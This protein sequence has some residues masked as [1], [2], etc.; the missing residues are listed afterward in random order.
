[1]HTNFIQFLDEYKN[2]SKLDYSDL[3][4]I[5]N[6]TNL[7][8]IMFVGNSPILLNPIIQSLDL[9]R[10]NPHKKESADDYEVWQKKHEVQLVVKT[11]SPS[12][13][14]KE[15]IFIETNIENVG[16]LLKLLESIS[17]DETKEYNIDLHKLMKIKPE[18]EELH[19]MIGIQELKSSILDQLFYFLQDLHLS[20]NGGDFKH[21]VIYG[22][23]GTGKTEVAKII[24]RMF[25][26]IGIL[27]NNV[28]KKVVRSDLVA[29]YLGQ[30]AI[31]TKT[32]IQESLGGVLFID[33]AYSLAFNTETDNY[34]QECIDTLCEALSD[35]KDDLMVIVAGYENE[36]NQTFFKANKGLESRFIWRFKIDNYTAVELSNIFCKKVKDA[37]WQLEQSM[38]LGQE[39]WFEQKKSD[40]KSFGRDM[41]ILF[42]YTKI[43]H[44][45]RIYGK[46]LDQRKCISIVDM[47]AGFKMFLKNKAGKPDGPKFG[48]MYI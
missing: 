14:Q 18:L 36:M 4:K 30:T 6:T 11:E 46:S 22:P 44:A 41:E 28:F 10:E 16:D 37:E 17:I 19:Q 13:P 39:K 26:K 34:S 38:V 40:F 48:H 31:K 5:I 2:K 7:H 21:T 15:K 47:D 20:P 9:S 27:K 23:P 35:H 29:G 45:R 25:S 43:C 12:P 42:L 24:G 1:M 32:I 33:E 3:L 8:Y